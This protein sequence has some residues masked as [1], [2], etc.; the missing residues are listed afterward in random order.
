MHSA[1]FSVEVSVTSLAQENEY[2]SNLDPL[3]ADQLI[4]KVPFLNLKK[5]TI[6]LVLLLVDIMP[7]MDEIH[8][9]DKYQ[10]RAAIRDIG[11]L[12]GSLKR[13]QVEPVNIIPELED[14]MNL[15]GDKSGLPPRDTLLHY[16]VWNPTDTRRRTY[17]GTQDEH[18]LIDSVVVAMDPLVQCIILLRKLHLTSLNSPEFKAICQEIFTLFE[19]VIEGIVMARRKVSPSYFANE[20]RFYFDPITL[21]NREYLGPGAVEM[22]MFVFDHLLWSS[23]CQDQE[24]RIFKETYLPYI[25]PEMRKVYH[26]FED[27]SSLVSK[28]CRLADGQIEFNN[29]ILDSLKSLS[30]CCRLLKSFRMPHKK[31]A[32]EAY[33]HTKKPEL[34]SDKNEHIQRNHGSGGYSTDILTHILDLTNQKIDMLDVC[35]SNFREPD[36]GRDISRN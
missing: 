15:L 7:S 9:F 1:P 23:D 32:E 12:L 13:H 5:D 26:E 16:T 20:L 6:E 35:I 29:M 8:T 19:K 28:V 33:A 34:L 18:Y 27:K 2:I 3:K 25:H 36:S 17:T 22:P 24:Y 31:I 14:K 10:A 30:S 4:H 11:F 21:N